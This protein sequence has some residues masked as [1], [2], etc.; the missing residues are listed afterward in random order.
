MTQDELSQV[1]NVGSIRSSVQLSL[2]NTNSNTMSESIQTTSDSICIDD[3]KDNVFN[4]VDLSNDSDEDLKRFL[5]ESELSSI[6]DNNYIPIYN[7]IRPSQ[8]DSDDAYDSLVCSPS[9]SDLSWSSSLSSISHDLSK[10]KEMEEKEMEEKEEIRLIGPPNWVA[11]DYYLEDVKARHQ[12]GESIKINYITSF[13]EL[14]KKAKSVWDIVEQCRRN[15]ERATGPRKNVLSNKVRDEERK[16]NKLASIF[17][18]KFK[19]PEEHCPNARHTS[20]KPSGKTRS[21]VI[22]DHYCGAI[23]CELDE[24]DETVRIHHSRRRIC[25]APRQG[26]CSF[27]ESCMQDGILGR[28]DKAIMFGGNKHY[29]T[30][31]DE[32]LLI[33]CRC[34]GQDKQSPCGRYIC[35]NDHTILDI[36][37]SIS[38]DDK[39]KYIKLMK[40]TRDSLLIKKY[41]PDIISHCI[42]PQCNMSH[43]GFV[44]DKI[45]SNHTKH[46]CKRLCPECST[47]W[48][49]D[50]KVT[51]YH[52]RKVC[53]GKVS[54]ILSSMSEEEK[55]EFLKDKKTCPTCDTITE[56]I[57]G[58]DHM[59]CVVCKTHWCWRCRDVRNPH[60]PYNHRCANDADY[61]TGRHFTDRG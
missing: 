7:V 42:N 60:D 51:P 39:L 9:N 28:M 50:C 27:L 52:E 45:R 35:A 11:I 33:P 29:S 4:V 26:L 34:Q 47:S 38:F 19:I 10:K 2:D 15:L 43:I 6:V 8:S 18:S 32:V 46:D 23:M 31:A 58:C 61:D 14:I 36:I 54:A 12:R 41:G 55:K 48:C 5:I 53:P 57:E 3:Q 1:E 16:Y 21:T 22:K 56:K 40:Q 59:T 49:N 13:E 17:R 30:D 25:T 24:K 37:E 44:V 20:N